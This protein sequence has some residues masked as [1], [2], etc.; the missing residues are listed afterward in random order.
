MRSVLAKWNKSEI[1]KKN[2]VQKT[3][4]IEPHP[5]EAIFLELKSLW[6][7]YSKGKMSTQSKLQHTLAYLR[8]LQQ[9]KSAGIKEVNEK[10]AL[11]YSD[12]MD[13]LHYSGLV[14]KT[15]IGRSK[16]QYSLTQKGE[17]LIS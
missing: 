5:D 4:L 16:S 1:L 12:I 6:R 7:K 14:E 10:L 8:Y 9:N 13:M 11:S 3:R 15:I 2:S 17:E